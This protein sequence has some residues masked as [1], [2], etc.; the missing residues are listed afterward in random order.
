MDRLKACE[1]CLLMSASFLLWEVAVAQGTTDQYQGQVNIFL[2]TSAD[3]EARSSNGCHSCC[4][5][6]GSQNHADIQ[7]IHG[8]VY[9]L[10]AHFR[11]KQPLLTMAWGNIDGNNE[12]PVQRR[13]QFIEMRLDTLLSTNPALARSITGRGRPYDLDGYNLSLIRRWI[14]QC[15]K[16]HQFTCSAK[17]RESLLPKAKLS[18]VDV[19]DLCIV[20]PNEP[21]RYAALSYV[22]GDDVLPMAKKANMTSLRLPGAFLKGGYLELPA[23][24]HDAVRVCANIGIRYLWVDSMCIVQDD[25]ESKME[26]IKAMSLIFANAYLTIVAL[27]SESAHS[28]LP[29][30][31]QSNSSSDLSP[32][33]HLPGQ[34]LIKASQGAHGLPPVFHAGTPWT[35][36]AWTLQETVLSKRLLCLGSL[37]TWA[38]G[39]ANWTEDLEVLSETESHPTAPDETLKLSIP[40][41]PD[42]SHYSGLA[43][44]YASRRL[45]MPGDTLNAFEGVMAPMSQ[46]IPRGFLFGLPE[47]LFDIGLLWQ[48]R[49]RGARPRSGVD[50]AGKKHEF[51]SWSWISHHGLH[52]QNFWEADYSYPRP[53]L[54]IS[55]LV[56]WK[57]QNKETEEWEHVENSYHVV[58]KHFENPETATPEGWTKHTDKHGLTYYQSSLYS[59]IRPVPKFSYPVPT[60][61]HLYNIKTASYHSHLR[62]EGNLARV[63]FQFRGTAEERNASNKK[64]LN[65]AL[66]PEM[67]IV[68]PVDGAWAGRVRLNMQ[69]GSKLPEDEEEHEVIAISEAKITVNAAKDHSLTTEA[70]DRDEV[71]YGKAWYHFVN[72]LWIGR[73]DDGKMYRK[74]LGRIWLEAWDKMTVERCHCIDLHRPS[75]RRTILAPTTTPVKYLGIMLD[76]ENTLTQKL[77]GLSRPVISRRLCEKAGKQN[78]QLTKAERWLFLSRLDLYGKTIAYPKSLD[79]TQFDKVCGRPPKNVLL[80]TIKAMTGLSSIPEVLREYWAPDRIDKLSY[81]ALETITMGWWTFDTSEVYAIDDDY[82]DDAVA[83][84]ASLVAESLRPEEFA[85]E[86]AVK[87]K[88][89]LPETTEESEGGGSMPSLEESE[90]TQEELEELCEKYLAEQDVEAEELKKALQEQL[91]QELQTASEEDLAAIKEL[92]ARMDVE[93]DEDAK[94]DDQRQ[95]EI[96]ELEMLE[97]EDAMDWEGEY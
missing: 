13:A 14:D 89:L 71:R 25:L 52:L 19:E 67:E 37:A 10:S 30:V 4:S 84:A 79:D 87:A 60:H 97:D 65:E 51:P 27:T 36:R 17:F 35:K 88:F 59:H 45:T 86:A 61:Q 54:T 57:K 85:F 44:A 15:D 3:L 12:D 78:D 90:K 93:A 75:Q 24:I 22:W 42:I 31:S 32:F 16:C 28:G 39:S 83:A 68:S 63:R 48:H 73:T 72:V 18:L 40:E 47:F 55:P 46:F 66:V 34:T 58:R 95:K 96:E 76:A 69:P 82:E 29:R 20:T 2:G 21:V 33:I 9:G 77:F 81:G 94:E 91:E 11:L 70:S 8:K 43:S 53:D 23:T 41:W 49:R 80:R 64:L 62:F 1:K 5:I 38:C 56:K 7:K 6:L 74:A 50:W 92:R 26:Q